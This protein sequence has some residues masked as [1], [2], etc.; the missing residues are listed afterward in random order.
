VA[1][2]TPRRVQAQ[3]QN[4]GATASKFDV[5]VKPSDL[6]T[7]T[8]AGSGVHMVRMMY[9]PEGFKAVNASLLSIIQEAYGIQAN[10]IVG[11][12]E[13]KTAA[14]DIEVKTEG[15][16]AN[17]QETDP[18]LIQPEIRNQLQ[19]LLADRFKLVLHHESKVLPSYVLVVGENGSKLQPTKY[20][21][22]PDTAKGPDGKGIHR[23]MMM[24]QGGQVRA[25]GAQKSSMA[26]LTR[27]LSMQ[28]AKNVV[29]KTGLTGQYDFNLQWSEAAATSD[30][31]SSDAAPAAGPSLFDAI[32]EQLGLKLVPQKGPEDVLIIDHVEWP[33]GSSSL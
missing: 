14:Y 16:P 21:D 31:A 8:Y 6:S 20:A 12:P 11:P 26:E 7:P 2:A 4:V 13:I 1:N 3:D 29:D 33:E 23:M 24:Q 5:S 19:A 17:A 28:L 22:Y 27:Q 18:R 32:Q 30:G 9:G 25:I 15:N 10:Q